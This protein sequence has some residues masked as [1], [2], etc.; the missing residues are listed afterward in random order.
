MAA[1]DRALVSVGTVAVARVRLR[2]DRDGCPRWETV[3]IQTDVLPADGPFRFVACRSFLFVPAV[4][5]VVSV[6]VA[7]E[8]AEKAR[9]G[10]RNPANYDAVGQVH[11]ARVNGS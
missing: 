8:P 7:A 5:I 6:F 3:A 10:E 11:E 4:T 1:V 2:A 9:R